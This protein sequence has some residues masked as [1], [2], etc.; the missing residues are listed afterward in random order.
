MVLVLSEINCTLLKEKLKSGQIYT[1]NQ[2]LGTPEG[3]ISRTRLKNGR[4][5]W[6]F[7]TLHKST[8]RLCVPI[9]TERNRP[10]F[11]FKSVPFSQAEALKG[12]K[13]EG[14]HASIFVNVLWIFDNIMHRQ[15]L[16]QCGI[17]KAC[18]VTNCCKFIWNFNIHTGPNLHSLKALD[19][20]KF[21]IP[22]DK[23]CNFDTKYYSGT[24][25]QRYSI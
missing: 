17:W 20:L 16:N 12:C 23:S 18:H 6:N 25:I 8:E 9:L 15:W 2:P 10:T 3:L 19:F 4:W 24:P 1:E 14:L 21:S 22:R 11:I 5:T 13:P 7:G